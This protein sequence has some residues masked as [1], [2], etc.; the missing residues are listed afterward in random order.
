MPAFWLS[1]IALVSQPQ[2]YAAL[3]V[4]NAADR[5]RQVI[6]FLP[7]T[8]TTIVL[9]MLSNLHG[10][11]DTSGYKKVF[12]A[13][14]WLSA[15]SV[16]IPT[17]VL[18]TL[19]PLAMAVFGK[20]YQPGWITLVILAVSAI[21][22]VLN[23]FLGQVLVSQG[24]IWWRCGVDALQAIVLVFCAWWLI[25]IYRENGLALAGLVAFGVSALA[26]IMP[27]HYYLRR[28]R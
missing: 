17:V 11:K 22:Y 8:L 21:F 16:L 7:S 24:L 12:S 28:Q 5:W 6:L 13:N 18:I 26:L 10:M 1:N 25:P 15:G 14:L 27:V 3:G 4:F 19:A 23:N 9:S 20:E 2:G